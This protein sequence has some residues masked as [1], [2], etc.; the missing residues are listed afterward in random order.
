MNTSD[1]IRLQLS[2]LKLFYTRTYL[3]QIQILFT[4]LLIILVYFLLICIMI[5]YM[6]KKCT[7]FSSKL[8]NLPLNAQ[9]K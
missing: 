9:I 1:E 3:N 8:T 2:I 4:Y 7:V 6:D 5:N